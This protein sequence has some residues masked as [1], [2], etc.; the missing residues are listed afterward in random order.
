LL[1]STGNSVLFKTASSSSKNIILA[2]FPCKW[3]RETK[4]SQ[5][6]RLALPASHI[7]ACGR[8]RPSA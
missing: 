4:K 2:G 8:V 7:A 6:R 1:D 5:P 3:N